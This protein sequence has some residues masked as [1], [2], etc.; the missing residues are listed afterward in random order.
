LKLMQIHPRHSQELF[1]ASTK[2][3]VEG[4]R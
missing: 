4:H 3:A 2:L 1:G